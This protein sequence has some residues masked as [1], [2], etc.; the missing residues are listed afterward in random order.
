MARVLLVAGSERS[1]TSTLVGVLRQLGWHVPQPELEPNE[2]N[3][4]GFGEPEWAVRFNAMTLEWA[5]V[6][7]SDAR[8]Q[9]WSLVDD[10]TKNPERADAI[11]RWLTQAGA[12][13]RDVVVKDPRLSWVYRQW[14]NAASDAGAEVLS[15]MVVRAPGE[16]LASKLKVNPERGFAG[17][18][19]GWINVS[20]RA[21]YVTRQERRAFVAYEDLLADWE[22]QVRSM[23]RQWGSSLTTP[24]SQEARSRIDQ[25]VDPSLHRNRARLADFPVPETLST[26][27]CELWNLLEEAAAGRD[28][29]DS[30]FDSVRKRY[31]ELYEAAEGIVESSFGALRRISNVRV[32]RLR[33]ELEALQGAPHASKGP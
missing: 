4:R 15:A 22:A 20:L 11:A 24:V 18:L 30:E 26:L 2:M 17:G 21:E 5:N 25:F 16:T 6:H 27:A 23:E 13:G 33:D 10:R 3:P 32:R 8:P 29:L 9:A 14:R 1:G 28:D 19:A 12:D 7:I 31:C